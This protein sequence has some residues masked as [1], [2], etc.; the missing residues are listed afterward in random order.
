MLRPIVKCVSILAL[1]VLLGGCAGITNPYIK[2]DPPDGKVPD[3]TK[4]TLDYGIKYAENAKAAYLNALGH[5]SQMA[6]WLGIGLIPVAA[7]ALGLGMTGQSPAAVT[8]LGLGAAS[9]YAIGTWLYSK[10]NQRAW[11]VGYNATTCAIDAVAPL[12]YVVKEENDIKTKVTALSVAIG[13]VEK[14]IGNVREQLLI[15]G[16]KPPTELVELKKLAEQR[17]TEAEKLLADSRET[18]RAAEKML[19]DASTAGETL[20]QTV[21]RISGQVSR[22]IVEEAADIQALASMIGGL[23]ASYGKFTA[24]PEGLRPAPLPAAKAQGATRVTGEEK[25]RLIDQETGL[26]NAVANLQKQMLNLQGAAVQ[27]ADIVNGVAAGKPIETL[28]ACGVN[29][30]QI[31]QPM[32][33]EP[34][35][36]IEFQSG[37]A[38]TVGR[39]IKG[40]S[41]PFA[42]ALQGDAEGPVVRQTEPFGPAFTVQITQN[43][44]AKE[45]TIYISDKAG[46][47]LFIP[48]DVKSG[49]GTAESPPAGDPI[50]KAAEEINS[51]FPKLSFEIPDQNVNV[52]VTKADAVNG[53]LQVDVEVAAKSGATTQQTADK[54]NDEQLKGEMIKYNPFKSLGI[55]KEK[56]NV[57]S[58]KAASK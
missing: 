12:L 40:G 6:T 33:V 39:V 25:K 49:T 17:V 2:W 34:P 3:G 14:E 15:V 7:A 21:D 1:G 31:S 50:S 45:Y 56:I 55:P 22:Q 26:R 38:A 27:V 16:D 32:T 20:K 47:K 57:R 28:R 36:R 8:G 18:R 41:A 13:S 54:V 42:V 51:S 10:P 53:A 46:R 24:V 9:G 19:Q 35:G 43:T 52:T 29:I 30:E 37:K 11:V 4:L 58:K 44:P 48:V 5:Q 23:A